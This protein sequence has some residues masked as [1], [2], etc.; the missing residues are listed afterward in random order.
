MYNLQPVAHKHQ[1]KLCSAAIPHHH[2]ESSFHPAAWDGPSEHRCSMN[3]IQAETRAQGGHSTNSG[4]GVM[5]Q[6]VPLQ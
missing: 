3:C 1:C 5:G 4:D 6:K 2:V